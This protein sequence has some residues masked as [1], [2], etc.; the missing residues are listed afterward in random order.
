[1]KKTLLFSLCFAFTIGSFAQVSEMMGFR[2]WRDISDAYYVRLQGNK[3]FDLADVKGSPFLNENFA[4]GNILDEN[5]NQRVETNLRYDLYNDVFEI[6]LDPRSDKINTLDRTENFVY[7]L[8]NEKFVL[9]KTNLLN[10]E[11]Y[12]SGNGYVVEVLPETNNV[13]LFKRYYVELRA[14][15]EAVTSYQEDIPPS[16]QRE[17]MYILKLEG[18]YYELP[19]DKKDIVEVFPDKQEDIRRYIKEKKF[20]FRGD[21]KEIQNQMLQVVRYY[22]TL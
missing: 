2:D 9:I 5:S 18:D 13:A 17:I 8:N 16:I 14:G 10:V 6:Q 19:A 4:F 11:H 15:S 12:T 3:K 21:D 20:K 1:M 7:Y 22:N